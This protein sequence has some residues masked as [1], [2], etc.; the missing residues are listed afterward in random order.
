[1]GCGNSSATS[2]TAGGP[3][4]AAKDVIS[5]LA[6]SQIKTAS[7]CE[8]LICEERGHRQRQKNLHRMMRNE[9]TTEECMWVFLLI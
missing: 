4:E 3:A 2:T 8:T 7:E 1:M 6:L 9:G 5:Q